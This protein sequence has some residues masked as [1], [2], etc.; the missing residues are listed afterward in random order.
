MA[1][2]EGASSNTD[3]GDSAS[4]DGRASQAAR[5]ID[6]DAQQGRYGDFDLRSVTWG[7]R[8]LFRRKIEELFAENLLGELN[9]EVTP[10]FFGMLKQADSTCFDHVLKCFLNSLTPE[11]K[12][13]MTMPALFED[14]CGLGCELAREHLYMGERYF[15]AWRRNALGVEPDRVAEHLAVMRRLKEIDA[16]L[17]YHYLKGVETLQE[18]LAPDEVRAFVEEA[19]RVYRRNARTGL[20]F[21]ALELK[22]SRLHLEELTREARLEDIK[23][24]LE[25]F[26]QGIAGRRAEVDNLGA[27]DSDELLERGTMHVCMFAWLYL[28]AR[29]R[30]FGARRL[31]RSWYLL[32]TGLSAACHLFQSF[33]RV[34]GEKGCATSLQVMENEGIP[35]PRE[36]NVLFQLIE[37]RRVTQAAREHFPGMGRLLDFGIEQESKM[38]PPR[39]TLD[40]LIRAVLTDQCPR[41]SLREAFG[42]VCQAA[43]EARNFYD[44]VFQLRDIA[45]RT[46]LA[47]G[48]ALDENFRH[49]A[50]WSRHP[51]LAAPFHTPAFFPDFMYPAKVAEPPDGSLA[52]DLRD[53]AHNRRQDDE[54]ESA[55]AG[56]LADDEDRGRGDDQDSAEDPQ[57]VTADGEG[58]EKGDAKDPKGATVGFFYDEWNGIEQEYYENWCCVREIHPK[59]SAH[60]VALSAEVAERARRVQAIFERLKPDEAHR[61]KR[62]PDGDDI[63][64]DL[65]LEFLA[66]KRARRSP[67][68]RFY[69]K[70]FTARR[71]LATAILIDLSGSTNEPAG[72][73]KIIDREKEAAFILAE[74][75]KR[76]GDQFGIFGFTGTGRER[77]EFSVFKDFQESWADASRRRLFGAHP[78]SST[79]IGAALRHCGWKLQQAPAR[80][81]VTILITDGKPMDTG[82]EPAN[83]Y[84]Q[85]DVRMACEENQRHDINTFCIST[86]AN[87]RADLELMFPRKRYLI[88]EDMQE[89]PDLLSRFYLRLTR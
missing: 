51:V 65:A 32:M 74:G 67:R 73:G 52:A 42:I 8:D 66:E 22:S 1:D 36:S 41:S 59:P 58:G 70:P 24:R 25:R 55:E 68:V 86:L 87:T 44:V 26:F 80:R 23:P 72:D 6:P 89:L 75:L 57:S 10:I 43:D 9:R 16:D 54:S 7:Y 76:L 37:L 17:A 50:G 60:T 64:I 14:W 49:A 71:S 4:G 28:P 15:Y 79:R 56:G 2:Y 62:L 20:R 84:A 63:D 12:W 69:S 83:R 18:R 38:R 77:C 35:W 39:T 88:I 21:L 3:P 53:Q 31:N 85:Y 82:Y 29:I 30:Q 5:R 19:L 34:Q 13:I 48:E 81:K 46:A 45:P 11:N 40:E 61:V 33:P 78:G 47:L 27:L